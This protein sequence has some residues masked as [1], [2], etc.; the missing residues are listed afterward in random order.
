MPEAG[1]IAVVIVAAG[2]GTR[3]AGPVPKQYRHLA[4]RAVLAHTLEAALWPRRSAAS[5]SPSTRRRA[6][7]MTPPSPGSTTPA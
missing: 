4:G 1:D 2:Q 3:L 5:S 7:S 6:R